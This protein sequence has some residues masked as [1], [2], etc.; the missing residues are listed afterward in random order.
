[1]HLDA[2]IEMNVPDTDFGVWVCEVRPT[3]KT[4]HLGHTALRARHRKGVDSVAFPEPGRVY[5]YRFDRFRWT[6]RQLQAGSRLRLVL[7]PLNTPAVQK[8]YQ[9]GGPPMQESAEDARTATVK[10]HMGPDRPSALTLPVRS[11]EGQ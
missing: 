9:S 7:A 10:L 2:W 5:R 6:A 3:G 1:M 8:N 4:I 11:D